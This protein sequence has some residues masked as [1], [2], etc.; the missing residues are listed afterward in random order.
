M[1][2][3]VLALEM[4]VDV[5]DYVSN[6]NN[7]QLIQDALKKKVTSKASNSEMLPHDKVSQSGY[8]SMDSSML[9][10]TNHIL[11]STWKK[12][13]RF[14]GFVFAA[15]IS[16]IEPAAFGHP[17][18]LF[19]PSGLIIGQEDRLIADMSKLGMMPKISLGAFVYHFKSVTVKMSRNKKN[20][21]SREDLSKY[22][23]ELKVPKGKHDDKKESS[24]TPQEETNGTMG[25]FYSAYEDIFIEKPFNRLSV[26]PSLDQSDQPDKHAPHTIGT[27][28]N[29]RSTVIAFAIS[30]KIVLFIQ[31]FSPFLSKQ[32]LS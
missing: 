26:Y 11:R 18:I 27:P 3:L 21:D 2:T 17:S 8:E 31:I 14:N 30:G 28:L 32:P 1:Q 10:E 16:G 29:R 22:H 7:V 9:S 23:L 25:K 20:E 4:S 15:N 13:A 5:E 12:K 24:L 6:P 19:D